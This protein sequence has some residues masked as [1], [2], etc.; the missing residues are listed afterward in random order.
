MNWHKKQKNNIIDNPIK[1]PSAELILE[2]VLREMEKEDER[3]KNINNRCGIFISAIA[4]LFT[5]YLPYI[6]L[7]DIMNLKINMIKEGLPQ[8]ILFIIY[9]FTLVLLIVSLIFFAISIAV[10]K[11]ERPSFDSLGNENNHTKPRD[12][13][14]S[15][16]IDLYCKNAKTNIESNDKKTMLYSIGIVCWIVAVVLMAIST[17]Y[18]QLM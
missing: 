13:M 3:S 8:I 17:I 6:A 7:N 10:K 12:V 2:V 18:R 9:I 15:S 16:I 11:Y 4:V 1:Y 14:A 5:F